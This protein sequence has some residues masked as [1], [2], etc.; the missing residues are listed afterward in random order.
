MFYR[1]YEWFWDERNWLPVGYTWR[2]FESTPTVT[3]PHP[4]DLYITPVLAV[5]IFVFRYIFEKYAALRLCNLLGIKNVSKDVK[6]CSNVIC[7]TAFK[8]SS[9]PDQAKIRELSKMTGWTFQAVSRWFRRRRRMR[10]KTPLLRKATEACWRCFVYLVLF[11][12]GVYVLFRTEWIWD[13]QQFMIGYIRTHNLTTE[14]RWYYYIELAL[15]LQMCV[16]QMTDT[17]RKDFWQ[18]YIHHVVTILLVSGSYTSGHFRFGAV[19]MFIHDA[20]DF[21]LEG[22]KV[23]NYAKIER[24]SEIFFVLFALTFYATR[25]VYFPF[26]I[27]QTFMKENARICG[28]QTSLYSFPYLMLYLCFVLCFLHI[29]W[30]VLVGRMVYK[31]TLAGKI[32]KDVRSDDEGGRNASDVG[33][34]D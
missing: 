23:C 20:S 12:Y 9:N 19:I 10:E 2:D 31:F 8:N 3:K 16:T 6:L 15:Y 24:L 22:A 33:D 5:G 11:V 25:W 32:E 28:S 18:Q 26:W 13:T 7:E 1:L 21:W 14:I 29:Y 34:T 27:L 30:G 17:K 4:K